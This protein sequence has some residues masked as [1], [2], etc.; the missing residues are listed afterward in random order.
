M[1]ALAKMSVGVSCDFE[2]LLADGDEAKIVM[3]QKATHQAAR[4]LD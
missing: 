1:P 4:C 2:L 3:R